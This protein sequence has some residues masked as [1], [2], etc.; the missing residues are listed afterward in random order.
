MLDGAS[1]V[2][3]D[4]FDIIGGEGFGVL[5]MGDTSFSTVRNCGDLHD[6][7]AACGWKAARSA[8]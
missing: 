3:V 2:V 6:G 4:G 5:L 7:W 8:T 1:H